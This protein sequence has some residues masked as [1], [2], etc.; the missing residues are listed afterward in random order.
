MSTY[1]DR[2]TRCGKNS[3]AHDDSTGETICTMCGYVILEESEQEIISPVNI[4]DNPSNSSSISSNIGNSTSNSLQETDA[5]GNPIARAIMTDIKRQ[6]I[7]ENSG[8]IHSAR[9]KNLKQADKEIEKL[10]DKLSLSNSVVE[11]T[12]TT[13]K[14]AIEK[15]ITRGHSIKGLVGACLYVSC[16]D[17]EIP[18]TINDISNTIDVKKNDILKCYKLIV[19]E[20]ELKFPISSPKKY[21]SRIASSIKASEKSKRK[22][23]AIIEQVEK[24][25]TSI[26]KDPI[27]VTAGALY[28]ACIST[29]ES[30][31]QEEIAK[32]SGVT[33]VT[34]RK[35]CKELIKIIDW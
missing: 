29:G 26:G 13:Y 32:A 34:I 9:D 30:K 7:L 25:G 16:R 6:K 1:S 22:A 17:S 18:R 10:K 5:F 12:T 2:C 31:S 4:S 35:R 27:G 14:K 8:R 23:M 11:K 21:V 3:I 33:E 24:T 15:N 20:L 19:A 28:L